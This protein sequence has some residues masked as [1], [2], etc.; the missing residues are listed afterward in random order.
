MLEKRRVVWTEEHILRVRS[1][2]LRGGEATIAIIDTLSSGKQVTGIEDILAHSRR[3]S[4]LKNRRIICA[5]IEKISVFTFFTGSWQ[6]RQ[7]SRVIRE[8]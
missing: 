5:N 1:D 2:T 7:Y 6:S 3:G 4:L 8:G